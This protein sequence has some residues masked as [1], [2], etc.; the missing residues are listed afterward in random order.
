[1]RPFNCVQKKMSSGSFKNVIYKIWLEII[2]LLY[3]DLALNNLQWWIC[4]KTKPNQFNKV[5]DKYSFLKDI[6]FLFI[7]YLLQ[8]TLFRQREDDFGFVQRSDTSKLLKLKTHFKYLIFI[9]FQT[10]PLKKT[11]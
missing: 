3:M 2:Y 9:I 11:V 5:Q 4:H 10:F 1:M 6:L 8:V 7:V